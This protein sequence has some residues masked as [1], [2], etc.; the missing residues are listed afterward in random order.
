VA[1]S[2]EC[3]SAATVELLLVMAAPVAVAVLGVGVL[4]TASQL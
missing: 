4:T 2:K 1:Q 3:S